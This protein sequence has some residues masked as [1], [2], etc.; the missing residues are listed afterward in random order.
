MS[1]SFFTRSPGLSQAELPEELRSLLRLTQSD[2]TPNINVL[3]ET[4]RDLTAMRFNIKFFGYE[5]ARRIAEQLPPAPTGGPYEIDLFSKPSTQA[6]LEAEWTRHWSVQ[7]G[8][9]H[10]FHRKLWELT[11]VLQVIWQSGNMAPGK[12]GL[13]FGC[14]EEPL[15]SYLAARGCNI[16]VTD[17]P[18]EDQRASG[19]AATAQHASLDN[20]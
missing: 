17:L 2:A 14:G 20:A 10:I 15:P 12:R 18:P 11:Y 7:L 9:A 3:N 6:D 16:T 8:V 4:L 13:G 5:M 1:S 19:W